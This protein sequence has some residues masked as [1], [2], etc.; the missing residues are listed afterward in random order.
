MYSRPRL[1][2]GSSMTVLEGTPVA[3]G[4]ASTDILCPSRRE[5]AAVIAQLAA[6]GLAIPEIA[7]AMHLDRQRVLAIAVQFRIRIRLASKGRR[8]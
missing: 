4:V 6:D 8:A 1:L 7:L 5:L 3:E 2:V